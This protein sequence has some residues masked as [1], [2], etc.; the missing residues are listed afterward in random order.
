MFDNIHSLD[1]KTERQ[2][3]GRMAKKHQSMSSVK[4]L[5]IE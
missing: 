4:I 2:I 1:M 3:G 5:K